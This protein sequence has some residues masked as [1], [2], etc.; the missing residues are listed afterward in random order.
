MRG[1]QLTKPVIQQRANQLVRELHYILDHNATMQ[2]LKDRI[3]K[4]SSKRFEQHDSLHDC[5]SAGSGSSSGGLKAKPTVQT[6]LKA[7]FS[8]TTTN[9]ASSKKPKVIILDNETTENGSPDS[10]AS[11]G[12]RKISPLAKD[13]SSYD[14][15]VDKKAKSITVNGH[16][17]R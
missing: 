12:K 6:G 9:K 16:A 4:T 7:F 5:S 15:P 11:I 13:P 10:L 8:A 2:L 14:S 1:L 3:N 17:Q